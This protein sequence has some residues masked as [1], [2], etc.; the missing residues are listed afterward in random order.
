MAGAA[1]GFV[2]GKLGGLLAQ[3]AI[4]LHGV[5]GEVEWLERELRRMQ[6]FLKDADAKKNKGDDERVKHWVTEMID[7]AF[8][9]EDAID[10]FMYFKLRR[11]QPGFM[12]FMKRFEF[13]FDELI[14]RHDVHAD[15]EG[16]KTKLQELSQSR[17][18]YG[19]GNIGETIG[20]T[21]QSRSQGVIPILPQL[22]DVIDMV[23]FD[24]EKKKIVQELVDI[25]NTNR[26]V[27][28]IVGMGGLG[29]TT[30]AKSVYNDHQVKRSFGIFAWV[31][32]SHQYTIFEIL[33]GVL[34]EKLETSSSEDTIQT[35]SVKVYEKLKK[36]KYLVVLDD[37]WK[38]DVWNELLKVFPDTNNGSRVI[39]TTR[40]ENVINIADPT[41]K[42]HKLRHLN[43]KESRELF[44][45]KVFPRQ[46]IETC[47][48]TCLVHYAQQLV[49]RCGGLP[50]ALVVLGGLIST[51]P[52][53]QDAW[54]KIVESMKGQFVEDGKWCLDILALSYNDL[55]YY[56][57]SC[58]LYF[59]CF[60]EDMNIPAKT[61]IRLWVAEGFLPQKNGTTTEEIGFDC[62]EE[63]EQ[64]C[65]IQVTKQDFDEKYCRIH[66]LLRDMCISEAK[67]SRF[68]ELY[69]NDTEDCTIMANAARR[70]I[71]FNEIETL[72]YSNSKLRGLFYCDGNSQRLHIKAL[73]GHLAR[74]K[75]LRVLILNTL[76]M[77]EFPSQIKSLIHLKYLELYA[78]NMKE[79]PSWIG[80]L[81]NLQT[82]IVKGILLEISDSIWTI[83]NLRHVE[84]SMSSHVDPPKMRNNVPK[85]LQTLKWVNAG[86]WIG[87]ALP[88]L[89]ILCEL[90]I[91]GV[92]NDHAGSLSSSLQKLGRLASLS[93]QGRAIPLDNIITAFSNQHCLKKLH[94][95]GSLNRKQLPHN[96]VFPQ[97]LVELHLQFSGLEQ[98]PMATLEKLPCLKYLV[99]CGAY[100]GK[101]MIC[102]A[103]GFP[104]LLSL[105]ILCFSELEEW[106]IEEKA[107]S[108]LKS[109][110]ILGCE[111]LKMIPEGLKNVPLHQ[112]KLLGMPGEFAI[113][114]KENTGEDWY[115]IQHVPNISLNIK[116]FNC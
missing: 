48:P 32:I 55:P 53:T 27:I 75:L 61:L 64:R 91:G 86:S 112:L 6:C 76:D 5:R 42:L 12:G 15:V 110:K 103:T 100:R 51:K 99:L 62:L 77:S 49:Q 52:Q 30:L 35:L 84:L 106:K 108:C 87:N 105:D 31:V 59:G 50:L 90:S 94:L 47:C 107:M 3:E 9:V 73:E 33:K 72:N 41:T 81:R 85:N 65:L 68:L 13:T 36:G 25:N 97:Q 63:L 116:T 57:K 2:A 102:S 109:L 58:F 1:V 113:R 39:I 4:N 8:E 96:D 89:T 23:G 69:K 82:F 93:I 111:R 28:S 21:S 16:I 54:H 44:L 95:D 114:M 67:E 11:Q 83:G 40:F 88:K 29:K 98:D 20:T 115:K 37:V 38:A 24:V 80:D 43:E 56:L 19:I 79:V 18:L 22:S 17:S 92:S 46:D 78:G 26:S 104:Q 74:Y 60:R 34:S 101:Q 66:D 10:T 7:L 14:S 71:I 45:R 70:L